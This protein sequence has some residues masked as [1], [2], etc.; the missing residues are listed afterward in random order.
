L[1]EEGAVK[2][3]ETYPEAETERREPGLV[4]SPIRSVGE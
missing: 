3:V 1:A 4:V 2:I